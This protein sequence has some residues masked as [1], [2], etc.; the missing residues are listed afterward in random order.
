MIVDLLAVAVLILCVDGLLKG[1]AIYI[2]GGMIC[3]GCGDP[4]TILL[5]VHTFVQMSLSSYG[6]GAVLQV[7]DAD[8]IQFCDGELNAAIELALLHGAGIQFFW[9]S[10]LLIVV[11]T[12]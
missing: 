8:F 5:L 10:T 7:A 1:Y 2:L 11:N 4:Y 6:L 3:N 9:G 12:S